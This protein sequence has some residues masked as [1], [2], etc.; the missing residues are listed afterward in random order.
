MTKKAK[1]KKNYCIICRKKKNV[2][3]LK[4]HIFS[5]KTLIFYLFVIGVAVKMKRHLKKKNQL[6]FSKFFV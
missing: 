5:K 3:I 6:K 2:K 1:M 4:Y